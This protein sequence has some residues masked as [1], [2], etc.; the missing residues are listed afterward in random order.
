M[1]G[2]LKVFGK[3]ISGSYSSLIP[4]LKENK[5]KHKA[6]SSLLSC[7][8]QFPLP[9]VGVRLVQLEA[10]SCSPCD[11]TRPITA[12][13]CHGRNLGVTAWICSG[14][15]TCNAYAVAEQVV[16][17]LK[18]G[19]CL[20]SACHFFLHVFQKL[21][22]KAEICLRKGSKVLKWTL[23]WLL[24]NTAFSI[25][26]LERIFP[27]FFF[28]PLREAREAGISSHCTTTTSPTV[29]QQGG[30]SFIFH[31]FSFFTDFFFL[32]LVESHLLSPLL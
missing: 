4:F 19:K 5:L 11:T 7:L 9:S 22:C 16:V 29:S 3:H 31:T 13:R 12:V 15:I 28:C 1:V 20:A 23:H 24:G 8:V 6:S 30:F 17:C 27:L 21:D 18:I 32:I 14:I 25:W 10:G 26:F 2:I